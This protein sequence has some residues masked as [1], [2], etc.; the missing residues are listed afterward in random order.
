MILSLLLV[1]RR[2]RFPR[3]FFVIE[4]KNFAADDLIIL[5]TFAG[6]QNQIIGAGLG[7]RLVD[8]FAAVGDLLVRLTGLL[9]SYFGVSQDFFGIFS[10]RIV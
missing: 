8:R 4:M 1:I 3:N 7:N 5:V 10:A 6:D 2:Q 9:D